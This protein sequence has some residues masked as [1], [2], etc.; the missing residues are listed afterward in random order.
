VDELFPCEVISLER[1][2]DLSFRLANSIRESGFAPDLMVAIARGG[3]VP[4]RLV[5]DFL[6]HSS[7]TSMTVRH[8]AAGAQREANAYVRHPLSVDVKGLRVL[9]VDDVNASGDTLEVVKQ[10]LQRL[11]AAETRF[12]VLHEKAG[13]C[14]SAD[15][16]V[17]RI[18]DAHWLIYQWALIEDALGFLASMQ[19]APSS[20]AA[21]EERLDRD[22][23]LKLDGRE[24]QILSASLPRPLD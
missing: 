18:E 24:W 10:E 9:V 19:P 15:Y 8:Y 12:G 17:E 6:Q 3:F 13:S 22:F 1:V 11:G 20:R 5:C 14:F 16:S 2:Y 21:A 4:A 7:L 23:G